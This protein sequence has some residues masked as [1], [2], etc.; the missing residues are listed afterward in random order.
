FD[1]PENPKIIEDFIEALGAKAI[2][3]PYRTECC[4]GYLSVNNKELAENMSE[5]IIRSA[6]LNGIEEIITACPL[7]KYNLEEKSSK[8]KVTYFTELLAEALEIK[9]EEE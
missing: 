3:Y 6:E 4:G 1:N 7:C 5:K 8:I 2:K 9:A